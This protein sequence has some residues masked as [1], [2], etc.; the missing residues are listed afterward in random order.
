MLFLFFL[1]PHGATKCAFPRF[2]IPF[3]VFACASV[4]NIQY[5]IP[6]CVNI[7]WW[8]STAFILSMTIEPIRRCELAAQQ[9]KVVAALVDSVASM[10]EIIRDKRDMLR[11]T[12]PTWTHAEVNSAVRREFRAKDARLAEERCGSSA[13][14]PASAS[15]R[16]WRASPGRRENPDCGQRALPS[17]Q[18]SG[19][20]GGAKLGDPKST[21]P[22]REH[23]QRSSALRNQREGPH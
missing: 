6:R 18:T 22:L 2:E 7:R 1:T 3:F 11:R 12:P 23:E 20:A 10:P 15:G 4:R 14:S 8:Q 16:L 9:E 5:P 17:I 21:G 19:S 13:K